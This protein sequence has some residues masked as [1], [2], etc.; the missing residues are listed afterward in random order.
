MTC[1]CKILSMW[2]STIAMAVDYAK[3]LSIGNCWN[4]NIS[5]SNLGW[6]WSFRYM[7][8]QKFVTVSI[9]SSVEENI[10]QTI[11]SIENSVAPPTI[12]TFSFSRGRRFLKIVALSSI[13]PDPTS[14]CLRAL[15]VDCPGEQIDQIGTKS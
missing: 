7:T 1:P 2:F 8:L 6:R 11:S 5:L 4:Q 14:L 15:I 12:V 3:L 9:A 10:L 13:T